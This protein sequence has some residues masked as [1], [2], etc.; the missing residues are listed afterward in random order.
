MSEFDHRNFYGCWSSSEKG[1]SKSG[2]KG[3]SNPDLCDVGAEWDQVL[4][5]INYKPA[6]DDNT[7]ILRGLEWMNWITAFFNAAQAPARNSLNGDSISQF[8]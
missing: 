3:D 4:L 8:S 6:D 2:L 1:L 7:R 5:W